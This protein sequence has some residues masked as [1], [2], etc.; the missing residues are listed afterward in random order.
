MINEL[1][2]KIPAA[3]QASVFYA[4][5]VTAN[6]D[7]Y[8]VRILGSTANFNFTFQIPD[9]FDTLVEVVAIVSPEGGAAGSGKD[10]DLMSQYGG[11]GEAINAHME[12]DVTSTYDLGVADEFAEIPLDTV[13]NSLSAG[14]VCGINIDQNGVG[15]TVNYYGILLRYTT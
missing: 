11:A 13:F 3:G 2:A 1:N 8:R 4:P 6:Q 14:D 7:T 15:G 9:D 10:I 12:S 5:D